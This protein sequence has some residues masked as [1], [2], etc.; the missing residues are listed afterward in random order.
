[1]ATYLLESVIRE[2]P[3]DRVQ[4]EGFFRRGRLRVLAMADPTIQR[5]LSAELLVTDRGNAVTLN[6]I[7]HPGLR[8]QETWDVTWVRR[9]GGDYQLKEAVAQTLTTTESA[10]FPEGL[11]EFDHTPA[12]TEV[13][14]IGGL[15]LRAA[16]AYER[17]ALT[18]QSLHPFISFRIGRVEDPPIVPTTPGDLPG[19]GSA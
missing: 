2:R 7:D 1:M 17:Y 14:G 4:V 5:Q 3:G 15:S 13:A 10:L 12:D 9:N 8:Q 19:H 11:P 6:T 18:L 16:L